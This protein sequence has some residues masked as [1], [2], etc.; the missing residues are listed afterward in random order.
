M[1]EGEDEGKGDKKV[2]L[3]IDSKDFRGPGHLFP[4]DP[5][6]KKF[7]VKFPVKF[8]D[9]GYTAPEKVDYLKPAVHMEVNNIDAT[10]LWPRTAFYL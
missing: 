7:E 10:Y 4:L 1:A 5:K 6:A 2:N 9:K 8:D 3:N